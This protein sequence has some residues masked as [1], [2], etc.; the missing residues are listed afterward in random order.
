MSENQR[1]MDLFLFRLVLEPQAG[2]GSLGEIEVSRQDLLIK[3]LATSPQLPSG[4]YK[5]FLTSKIEQISSSG[6]YF[7]AGVQSLKTGAKF[8]SEKKDFVEAETEIAD[9]SHCIYD[10]NLQLLAI[11]NKSGL[12]SPKTLA[13]R[14]ASAIENIKNTDGYKSLSP[15]EKMLFSNSICKSRQVYETNEFIKIL[16]NSYKISKFTI[17]MLLPNPAN[18]KDT[19][20]TPFNE[21]ME[22]TQASGGQITIENKDEGLE[23]NRLVDLSHDIGAYG[24]GASAK[25]QDAAESKERTIR[26]DK[27]ENAAKAT[28]SL[29]QT[30][31]T[32]D[33]KEYSKDFLKVITDKFK[34]IHESNK[35][36]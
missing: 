9:F 21:L 14:L 1:T 10:K 18:F 25:V 15:E 12:S 23:P 8:D 22:D 16:K 33:F 2:K 3:L 13:N 19:I 5:V 35:K 34:Q 24:A 26:L 6:F 4:A 17:V 28:L 31:F 20:Y 36:E 11:E 32:V 27:R 29:P 30:M 7:K